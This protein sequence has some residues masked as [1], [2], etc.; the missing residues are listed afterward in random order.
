MSDD[1]MQAN[2]YG[3]SRVDRSVDDSR[4]YPDSSE[5]EVI[6]DPS[7]SQITPEGQSMQDDQLYFYLT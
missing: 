3:H 6:A 5:M 2:S 1:P 4:Q 7:S